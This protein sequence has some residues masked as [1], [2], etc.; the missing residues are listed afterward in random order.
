MA[1]SDENECRQMLYTAHQHVG[2]ASVRYP[3]GGGP[4][5]HVESEMTAL[6]IGKAEVLRRGKG[7]ALLAFGSLVEDALTIGEELD[8]TVVNMRFVKPID[9]EIIASMANDHSAFITLEE[10]SV[11]GGA[12]SAVCESLND[13]EILKPVLQIGL[14]D[15]Y[16]E[17]GSREELL[18]AAKLDIDSLRQRVSIYS[19]QFTTHHAT[20][21]PSHA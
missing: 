2:P 12:G 15:R 20:G 18:A 19:A 8:L 17:H 7:I 6:P 3:R 11:M 5:K 1:P 9:D 10:N 13:A 14:P 16:L 4:G 21:N